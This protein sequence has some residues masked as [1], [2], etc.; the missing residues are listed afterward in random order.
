[1]R[2]SK[3][4]LPTLKEVPAEAEVV[5]HKLLLRAGMIRKLASGLY[6]YLP[7]GLRSLRKVEKI[8]REEM[9]RSGAQEVLLPIVQPSELWQESGRW[10]RYGKELLRFEDRHGRASCLGPTHEEVITDIVRKEVRSY[11]DFPLNLYQIQTKF[12]DEIRPRFGLMRGRE[13]LMKDAYSFDVD[14]DALEKTYQVMYKAYCRIFERCGLDFR[15]VEADTGSI[16]GHASH[17]FMVMADTGEDQIAC[18]TSCDYAANVELAPVIQLSTHEITNESFVECK[19]INTPG[20][21]S[22]EEVAEFL[23]VS[24]DRLV[25]TLVMI[26]DDRPVV[27]L[28]RGDHELNEVKLKRLLGAEDLNFADEAAVRSVTGAPVG[29]AGPVGLPEDLKVVADQ[30]VSALKN[31]VTGANEL[32]A[33]FTGV[34]WNRDFS[35]PEFADIRV[36]TEGDP[37]PKCK[38]KIE[39]RRGIEVGH[40]FKLGTKYSEAMGATFLDA[41]GKKQSAVMGCYGIGVGRTVA[42]AIEQNHD[43]NGIIFPIPVAPFEVIISLLNVKDT[44]MSETAEDLYNGLMAQGVDVLLDDR[45]ERPGVKFKDADLLGI[46]L[47]IVVGKRL[48]EKDEVEIKNRAT[49]KTISVKK[50]EAV[51]RAVETLR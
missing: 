50:N 4:F 30:G 24:A 45:E 13:F 7:L 8:I 3:F 28:I 33:H 20:K 44:V 12:R 39:L 47:R 11:R 51:K 46:P 48:K 38:G 5:S 1:M 35:M 17:E 23:G 42:A 32:D 9:D 41:D 6:S 49:G 15:P 27:A 19:K 16:G 26:A 34:N 40:I 22:A 36:I 14:D 18:C 43:E 10:E 37:C 25:K 21:R 31:F 29:F 2:Y